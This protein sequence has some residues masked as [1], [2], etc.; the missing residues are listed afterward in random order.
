MLTIKDGNIVNASGKKIFLRGINL[1]GWLMM[2][3]YILCGRNISEQSFKHEMIKRYGRKAGDSFLT[4]FRNSFVKED[5]FKRISDVG[6]NCVRLPFNF[7]LLEEKKGRDILEKVIGWC[8]KYNIYCILDMH[9]A[10][11]CQ[12]P[13]WHSDSNGDS[14]LWDND[15]YQ[16]RFFRLWEMLSDRFKDRDIIAGYDVL[17]EPVIRK[18]AKKTLRNFYKETIRRIREIDKRHIIFLEGNLWAQVLED[19]GEPFADNL[20]YS[21]H[22]YCPIDFTFDFHRGLRYPGWVENEYWNKERI[23]DDLRRYYRLGRNW[24]V[25]IFVGEFGINF[26]CGKCTG[27]IAWVKDILQIFNK[28]D[29][30]WTYW[31]YKTIANSVYPDGLYRYL[32]NPRWVSREGPIYGWENFYALWKDFKKEI[33]KSWETENFERDQPLFNLLYGISMI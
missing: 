20:S 11:G 32:L 8:E 14:Y 25:P 33:M 18:S 28:F 22:Y 21:I 24:G 1:G 6:M 4:A 2:E 3:G 29:F 9:A 31:T 23:E 27:S 17:N 19:I 16:K 7:R 10:P 5:D 13:D 15:I 12:N 26:R 30:H